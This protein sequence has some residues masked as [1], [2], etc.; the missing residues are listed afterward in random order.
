MSKAETK[1]E[2][3]FHPDQIRIPPDLAP[4]L[5]GLTKE[6]LREQIHDKAGIVKFSKEYFAKM[7]TKA[8]G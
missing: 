7:E 3:I 2:R 1:K 4:V 6:I 8:V 5:K